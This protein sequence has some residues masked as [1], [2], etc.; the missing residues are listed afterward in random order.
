[1]PDDTR[2]RVDP[3]RTDR[4]LDARPDRP[5]LVGFIADSKSEEAVREGLHD[6]S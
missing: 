3:L 5:A 6:L 1:M 4:G 2:P